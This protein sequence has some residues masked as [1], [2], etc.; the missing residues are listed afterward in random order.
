MPDGGAP[1]AFSPDGRFLATGAAQIGNAFRIRVLDAASAKEVR[2]LEGHDWLIQT[3]VFSPDP[4]L[5]YL[6]SASLDGT[7]WIWDVTTGKKIVDSP[8]RH[9][10]RIV[11]LAFSAEGRFLA[12]GG[13]D[14]IIKIWDA[15]SWK[16]LEEQPDPTGSIRTLMF[17]PTD[18]RLLVWGSSDGTVKILDRIKREVTTL[19]GHRDFVQSVTFSPDGE[20]IASASLDKTIKVWRTPPVADAPVHPT[21]SRVS[22]PAVEEKSTAK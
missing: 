7:V 21:L 5:A 22:A 14:R 18:S 13:E 4:G 16:L 12:S 17:H 15:H 19:H 8:L 3:L 2:T 20:W 10:D 6:A 11:G 1:V 9:E